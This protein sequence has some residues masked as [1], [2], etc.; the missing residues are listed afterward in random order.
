MTPL[1]VVIM[2]AHRANVPKAERVVERKSGLIVGPDMEQKLAQT[3]LPCREADQCE[4]RGPAQATAAF[5]GGDRDSGEGVSIEPM[6]VRQ[7]NKPDAAILTGFRHDGKMTVAVVAAA[8][9]PG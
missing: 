8:A 9:E 6:D 2:G 1:A 5:M 4:H 3:F 7:L